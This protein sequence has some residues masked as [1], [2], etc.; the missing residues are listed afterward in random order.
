LTNL[1]CVTFQLLNHA[2][3]LCIVLKALL[4]QLVQGSVLVGF[5][6]LSRRR[7]L[8]Q[9]A[10]FALGTD[11]GT[12]YPAIPA[13]SMLW[14]VSCDALLVLKDIYALVLVVICPLFAL[15]DLYVQ[16]L[17]LCHQMQDAL[18]AT[19]ALAERLLQI[20]FEKILR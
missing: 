14:W 19:F 9:S 1:I 2:L 10:L 20:H 3:R 5:T 18:Q 17:D 8:A 7:F 4:I 11:I 13:L 6:V 15:Q 16:L 12:P